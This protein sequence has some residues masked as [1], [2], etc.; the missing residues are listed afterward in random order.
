M[1]DLG[2]FSMV[3]RRAVDVCVQLFWNLQ[4]WTRASL[5]LGVSTRMSKYVG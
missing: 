3:F 2:G 1:V 4:S 5:Y